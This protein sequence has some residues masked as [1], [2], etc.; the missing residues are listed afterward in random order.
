M[1]QA[2]LLFLYF[3]RSS[4]A[5]ASEPTKTSAGNILRAQQQQQQ[6]L[7]SIVETLGGHISLRVAR[8]A[9]VPMIQRC[10]L[11]T[12]PENY[13]TNFYANHM[14]RWPEL[15][16]VAEHVPEGFEE[17]GQNRNY[18]KNG[19]S[20]LGNLSGGSSRKQVSPMYGGDVNVKVGN[21][22]NNKHCHIIGYVLGKVEETPVACPPNSSYSADPRSPSKVQDDD[23]GYFPFPGN[24]YRTR[25]FE[26]MG[27][28]TSLAILDNYRRKG[29]AAQLMNQ[30]HHE[31]NKFYQPNAVGLH[32][33]VSNEAATKL[34]VDTLGY[35]VAD[36][37]AGYYQDGEDAY[38]MRR[39]LSQ[40][41]QDQ[42]SLEQDL[43]MVQ[44]SMDTSDT[45]SNRF[46]KRFMFP[47]LGMTRAQYREESGLILPRT[48]YSF[49]DQQ[50]QQ[51]QQKAK[52]MDVEVASIKKELDS[53]SAAA[54]G[55][56]ASLQ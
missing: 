36:V 10:N 2:K 39:D 32:V 9:D 20:L 30:L 50:Q 38:L 12:L 34:Y 11:A 54:V 56:S 18:K 27:H 43:E 22:N 14:R 17:K 23:D 37:I 26:N 55:A 33:R 21:G 16:L 4:A 3:L 46:V 13:N 35:R 6:Q 8:R 47:G 52:V 19:R 44:D 42:T 29:L 40:T 41:E 5:F 31:M 45:Q 25:Q 53:A 7:Q 24:E 48:I 49:K 28:V 1:D 51:Q 15:A